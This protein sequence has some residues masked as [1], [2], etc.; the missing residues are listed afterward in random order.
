MKDINPCERPSIP[1]KGGLKSIF[2]EPPLGGR[3]QA[4]LE[5]LGVS[6]LSNIETI[7]QIYK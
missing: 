2:F 6:L 4:P 1:P 7:F 5:G 3:G